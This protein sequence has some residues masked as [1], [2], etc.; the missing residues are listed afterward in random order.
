MPVYFVEAFL[1]CRELVRLARGMSWKGRAGDGRDSHTMGINSS[2]TG[3][4]DESN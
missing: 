1:N 4:L 2:D 3:L